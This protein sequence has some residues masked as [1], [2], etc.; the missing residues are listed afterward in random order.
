MKLDQLNAFI[1][2]TIRNRL[3]WLFGILVLVIMY[4]IAS[5]LFNGYRAHQAT[6]Q[7][8]KIYQPRLELVQNIDVAIQKAFADLGF[9]MM[10]HDKQYLV[11]YQENIAAA[12]LHVV[13]LHKAASTG[14]N[15]DEQEE[16]QHLLADMDKVTNIVPTVIALQDNLLE[17]KPAFKLAN[18]QLEPMGQEVAGILQTAF[19]EY[20][21]AD[22]IEKE[23]INLLMQAMFSWT[24]MR[25]EIRAFLSFRTEQTANLAR[26]QLELFGKKIDEVLEDEEID[27]LIED[28]LTEI[29]AILPDF[30]K[31]FR[32]VVRLHMSKN[33]L[34]QLVVMESEVKPVVEDLNDDFVEIKQVNSEHTALST[35]TVLDLLTENQRNGIFYAIVVVL[36][37]VFMFMFLVR[38]ILGP[39]Q[40][41]INSMQYIAERGDLEH[42][43]AANTRDEYS[44]LADAF[45]RFITKIKGVVNLVIHA[46]KNLVQESDHLSEVTRKSE[47]SAVEQEN[48]VRAIST[49]FQQLN[50][51]MQIVQSNTTA[52]AEAANAANAYSER[53]QKVVEEIINSMQALACQ[54]DTTHVKIEQLYEMSNKIDEVVKVIRGIT[55]QTNLLALNAAIEA[56][57]AG[58]QG[59]GFAVV[60]DE[61]RKLS[62][63]VQKETDSVNV[64]IADLQNAV[65]ETLQSMTQSKQQTE[66]NVDMV[67]RAGEALREIHTSVNVIKD[68]NMS[69][70]DET[71]SQSQQSSDMLSKLNSIAALAEV[72]AVSARESSALSKEFKVL[73]QQLEDMVQQFLFS[74]QDALPAQQ[75]DS[76]EDIELF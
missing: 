60:A 29:K 50:D 42:R 14:M 21:E 39:L 65:S 33:W 7:A 1:Q 48:E 19:Q 73:A 3:L 4:V 68:M 53:G 11:R 35:R 74:K 61:V 9:Y 56:A 52:A 34:K 76:V 18:T 30:K 8:L 16:I 59:R 64:Q 55:D 57:R 51:S 54:V 28:S 40:E 15:K 44:T 69:I 43:M 22:N 13:A 71:H 5:L 38:A 41:S 20:L 37:C 27:L 46:S 17:N 70:A 24:R 72:S 75:D 31:K 63:D 26:R 47:Q 32:E 66:I 2:P 12:K 23:K 58:E 67:S 10:S 6:E 36:F 25:A 49:T 45:N 62:Q